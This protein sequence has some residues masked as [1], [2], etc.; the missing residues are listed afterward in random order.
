MVWL[1]NQEQ[2][3]PRPSGLCIVK[4]FELP[5]DGNTASKLIILRESIYSERNRN[6]GMV[7]RNSMKFSSD[8]SGQEQI[9]GD[10]YKLSCIYNCLNHLMHL[11]LE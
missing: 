7:L 11:A 8:R 4:A 1:L 9:H 2:Y 6:W 5:V 10:S 3:C